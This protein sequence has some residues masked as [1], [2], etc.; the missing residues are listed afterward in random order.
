MFSLESEQ[1]LGTINFTDIMRG[2]FQGCFLGYGIDQNLQGKGLM[3]EGHKAAID[4]GTFFKTMRDQT[5][6]CLPGA[7]LS[8]HDQ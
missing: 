3:T 7:S 1:I 8:E 2:A 4:I 6:K 5:T